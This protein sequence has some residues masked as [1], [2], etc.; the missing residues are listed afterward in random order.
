MAPHYCVVHDSLTHKTVGQVMTER[1]AARLSESKL[2]LMFA[3]SHMDVPK[4]CVGCGIFEDE[5][6]NLG[7]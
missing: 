3:R 7:S 2:L 6:G 1:N 4:S 5:G